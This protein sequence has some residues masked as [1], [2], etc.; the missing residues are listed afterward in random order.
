MSQWAVWLVRPASGERN[1]GYNGW[2]VSERT[3]DPI[4]SDC[5]A[6]AVQRAVAFSSDSHYSEYSSIE[7]RRYDPQSKGELLSC[8]PDLSFLGGW[9]R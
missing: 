4:P 1:P 8:V 2:L 5:P 3:Y 9:F 6:H 7:V